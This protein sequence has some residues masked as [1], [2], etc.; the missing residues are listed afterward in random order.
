[1][2]KLKLQATRFKLQASS[3]KL[4]AIQKADGEE[5]GLWLAAYGLYG[6]QLTAYGLQL[7]RLTAYSL[8]LA[9][10][11]VFLKTKKPLNTS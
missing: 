2:A 6:L 4:Q 1:M 8:W 9:A 3:F 10:S 7:I 5:P 11:P